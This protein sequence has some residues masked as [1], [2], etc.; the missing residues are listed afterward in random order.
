M[1]LPCLNKVQYSVFSNNTCECIYSVIDF[2]CTIHRF[3]VLFV[4]SSEN[5]LKVVLHERNVFHIVHD[6][7]III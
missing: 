3:P 6:K 4:L 5:W 1:S 7:L 2:G